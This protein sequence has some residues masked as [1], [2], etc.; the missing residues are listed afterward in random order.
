MLNKNSLKTACAAAAF[1]L[2]VGSLSADQG[3]EDILESNC[4]EPCH[5]H[6]VNQ[7]MTIDHYR[8]MMIGEL[9]SGRM[10]RGKS[11]L[12]NNLI[13]R[14]REWLDE[15]DL[16]LEVIEPTVSEVIKPQKKL[17]LIEDHLNSLP[18]EEREGT[19]YFM[20]VKY[21]RQLLN[22]LS[23][24]INSVSWSK[25]IEKLQEVEG[26]KNTIFHLNLSKIKGPEFDEHSAKR[27]GWDFGNFERWN[28]I[29][30]PDQFGYYP[31][32]SDYGKPDIYDNIKEMTGI[33][34]PIVFVDWFIANVSSGQ[35]LY[36][37]ALYDD[38][39]WEDDHTI[40]NETSLV[41]SLSRQTSEKTENMR[42]SID[43]SYRSYNPLY[44]AGGV[45]GRRDPRNGYRSEVAKYN[46]ILDR[47]TSSY[48]VYW[49]SYDFDSND[50][51]SNIF[52]SIKDFRHFGNEMIFNL[53]NGFHA[54]FITDRS[55]NRI[56]SAPETIVYDYRS[57][58]EVINGVSCMGCHVKGIRRFTDELKSKNPT[59][60]TQ[61]K[62]DS[63][64]DEDNKRYE[65]A[66][67]E[68]GLT[69]YDNTIPE[70][71]NKYVNGFVTKEAAA[72][73]FGLAVPEYEFHIGR[74]YDGDLNSIED[75]LSEGG[76]SRNDWEEDFFAIQSGLYNNDL[77]PAAARNRIR[78]DQ[79]QIEKTRLLQNYPNP[80]NPETWI[81]YRLETAA[82]VT[83]SIYTIKGDLVRTLDLGHQSAGSYESRSRAAYWDGR[84]QVGERVSTG[85]YYYALTAGETNMIG[86]MVVMK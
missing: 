51:E 81:P 21:D 84:N 63:Y 22:S 6:N 41:L 62:L 42:Q 66:F 80:F 75:L 17:E 19:I 55:G 70:I 60:L 23:I 28:V 45:Y 35:R 78:M 20:M 76:V 67:E 37:E 64:V 18:E 13:E 8:D 9:E 2:A 48:G 86:K 44:Q 68:L 82:D 79:L 72:K 47:M 49:K 71:Y 1:S 26:S 31:Y 53:P 74:I 73:I 24:L 5:Y 58:S 16:E 38:H 36:H 7:L 56:E 50:R 29:T 43:P 30:K 77:A 15:P 14:I 12:D 25:K 61:S 27:H 52:N 32:D 39:V 4:L 85:V 69:K 3:V 10:P 40:N 54:Y 34:I 57:D 65:A 11:R 83:I 46:R 59:E 33:Q